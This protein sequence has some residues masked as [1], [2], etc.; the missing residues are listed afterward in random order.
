MDSA[1]KSALQKFFKGE[2]EDDEESLV[3]F[4]KDASI[5]EIKP[6]LIASPKDAADIKSL[7]KF[8]NQNPKLN[9]SITPRAAGTCMSGGAI[10]ESIILNTMKYLNNV[11]SVNEDSATTEPG[12]LYKDFEVKTLEKDLLLPC[13]TS[14]REMNT[15][16]GM[17]GNNSAGELSLTYGQTDRWVKRLKVILNDGNEYEIYPMTKEELNK[18]MAQTDFEGKFYREVYNLLE[19]NYLKIH[20]AKPKTSKNSAGYYV[21]NV[22]DGHT[23]D[24]TKLFTGSQGTL[25]VVT[26]IEF[27]LIHPK[28]NATVLIISLE[29]LTKLDQVVLNT[30]EQKPESFECYDNQT[31][32]VAVKFLHDL[33]KDFKQHHGL[34][35]YISFISEIIEYITG[36]FPKLVLIA[37]FTGDTLEETAKA[38]KLSQEK[39]KNLEIKSKIVSLKESEKYWIIRRDS[40]KLLKQHAVHMHASPFID[41]FTVNPNRLPE[42]LPKFTAILEKYNKE[43]G[44]KMVVTI[45]GHIGNGNFHVIPL[46]DLTDD[47]VRSIIPALA[48]E[49]FDLVFEFEGTM[50]AEHNDGLVRGP[51]LEQMYGEDIYQVFKKIKEIFDPKNIFNP[52]KKTDATWEYSLNHLSK[53]N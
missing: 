6:Q 31:L 5:F 26:E 30:L 24:L 2:L 53:V 23:F 17:V 36:K 34:G 52:H 39:L 19:E 46:M 49:V 12:V 45:A 16:G 1:Q 38:A 35:I 3:K 44:P 20:Y 15:V 18:K 11:I 32:K 4:S 8:I 48:K 21:W 33:I 27:N 29:D 13:Y 43:V 50:A 25:G 14:S 51:F 40:F 7:I 47:H 10:G 42:F 22:W 9:L 41:D 37:E 28:K